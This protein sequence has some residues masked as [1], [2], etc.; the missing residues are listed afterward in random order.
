MIVYIVDGYIVF[1]KIVYFCFD[2]FVFFNFL[3]NLG[4]YCWRNKGIR[5]VVLKVF[6]LRIVFLV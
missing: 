3:I 4:I 1:L 5:K 2:M 6:L